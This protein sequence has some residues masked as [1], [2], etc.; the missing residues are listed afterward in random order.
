MQVKCYFVPGDLFESVKWTAL[1]IR[2]L[3]SLELADTE[4]KMQMKCFFTDKLTTQLSSYWSVQQWEH[5]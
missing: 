4:L 1:S 3:P 2:S 5:A